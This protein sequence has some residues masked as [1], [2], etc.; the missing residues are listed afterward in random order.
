MAST[1][2]EILWSSQSVTFHVV[3]HESISIVYTQNSILEEVV[4]VVFVD[5]QPH[6][7]ILDPAK[8]ITIGKRRRLNIVYF[9]KV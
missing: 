2:E 6:N 5:Q 9:K 1:C 7:T 8:T 4:S 3:Y